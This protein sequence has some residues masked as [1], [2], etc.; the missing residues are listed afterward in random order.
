MLF[1]E[2]IL[3]DKYTESTGT[4]IKYGEYR[5]LN[6]LT[7][8][9]NFTHH[10]FDFKRPLTLMDK[11]NQNEKCDKAEEN[12]KLHNLKR[13]S[14]YFDNDNNVILTF[15]IPIDDNIDEKKYKKF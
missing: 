12:L 1:D 8:S 15:Y 7:I 5:Y 2:K 6:K 11:F 9:T 13:K 14:E 10:H 4:F 3:I